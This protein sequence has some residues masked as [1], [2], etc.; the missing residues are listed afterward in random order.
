[1]WHELAAER[2]PD[3]RYVDGPVTD[4]DAECWAVVVTCGQRPSVTLHLTARTAH[5]ELAMLHPDSDGV[6]AGVGC[7]MGCLAEHDIVDL[8]AAG[9]A[10]ADAREFGSASVR[11][12]A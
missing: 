6:L 5:A 8:S 9:Q 1:M 3:A 11:K 7:G 12:V 4:A 2:W 10:R